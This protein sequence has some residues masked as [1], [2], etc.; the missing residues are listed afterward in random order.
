MTSV[1]EP[2]S[3]Y[4]FDSTRS[5]RRGRRAFPLRRCHR[6]CVGI[7]RGGVVLFGCACVRTLVRTR[8]VAGDDTRTSG[9][10][11]LGTDCHDCGPASKGNFTTFD[12]DGWWDDDENYWD[13]DY[14]W[15]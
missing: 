7:A 5:P 1:F 6:R 11:D 15:F 3:L 9:L 4:T 13:D 10:C 14:D 2:A 12:D 8:P